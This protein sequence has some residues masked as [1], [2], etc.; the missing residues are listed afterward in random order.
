MSPTKKT[1]SKRMN[2]SISNEAAQALRL[3]ATLEQRDL[4]EIAEEFLRTGGLMAEFHR[5]LKAVAA[6]I[7]PETPVASSKL[8]PTTLATKAEIRPPYSSEVSE[9]FDT[10][11]EKGE[12]PDGVPW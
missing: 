3:L 8:G 11:P 1:D 6:P 12:Y 7:H 10:A 4:G 2:I 5:A 9:A